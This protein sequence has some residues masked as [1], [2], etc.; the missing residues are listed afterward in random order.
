MD[1][2]LFRV[3]EEW[4]WHIILQH[5][6]HQAEL[7]EDK[8]NKLLALGREL[9]D[10]QQQVSN[11]KLVPTV[12]VSRT[13]DS[14]PV[15]YGTLPLHQHGTAIDWSEPI[16]YYVQQ[17]KLIIIYNGI[18]LPLFWKNTIMRCQSAAE[19][20]CVLLGLLIESMHDEMNESRLRIEGLDKLVHL[21][22]RKLLQALTERKL[23]LLYLQQQYAA[24]QEALSAGEE[25]FTRQISEAAEFVRTRSKLGRMNSLL[26]NYSHE[27]HTFASMSESGASRKVLRWIGSR[28]TRLTEGRSV[29][30]KARGKHFP[31]AA[32][33]PTPD[34][35]DAA[36]GLDDPASAQ[37]PPRL[38]TRGA[39]RLAASKPNRASGSKGKRS[40]S[41]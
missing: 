5:P 21:P 8:K 25:V 10:W 17:H 6:V 24:F 39:A 2:H 15:L 3:N 4:E 22:R 20:Y 36:V 12:S 1:Y 31:A 28:F 37:L 40:D 9:P 41:I 27:L 7:P 19:A 23:K 16:H 33:L 26:A 11:E 18:S 34:T 14:K 30:V 38:S 29:K 13:I 35:K 32:A